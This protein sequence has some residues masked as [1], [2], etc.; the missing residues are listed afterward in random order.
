MQF[1]GSEFRHSPDYRSVHF[2]GTLYTLTSLQAQVVQLLHEQYLNGTP[3]LGKDY[4]LE[5]LGS[6]SNRLRDVF[7]CCKNWKEIIVPGKRKGTYRI[8]II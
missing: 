7:Q 5:E 2:N 6:T 8:N 3:E 4:I 1:A